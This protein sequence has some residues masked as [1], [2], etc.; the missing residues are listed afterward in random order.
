[1]P[2]HTWPQ[3]GERPARA[4]LDRGIEIAVSKHYSGILAAEFNETA[5]VPAALPSDR[6][7]RFSSPR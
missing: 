5:R 1:V 6:Q 4:T 7:R 3:V 2:R